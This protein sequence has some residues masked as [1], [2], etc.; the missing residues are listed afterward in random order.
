[1][2]EHAAVLLQRAE[3]LGR[4]SDAP[5][6][7]GASLLGGKA[8]ADHPGA[9]V[10]PADRVAPRRLACHLDDGAKDAGSPD[11]K[12]GP[13]KLLPLGHVPG[14]ETHVNLRTALHYPL[15]FPGS[16]L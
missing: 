11:G 1:M 2:G 5:S 6:V 14:K 4:S 9:V 16:N 7:D 12:L 15:C 13:P 8:D 3:H 10:E